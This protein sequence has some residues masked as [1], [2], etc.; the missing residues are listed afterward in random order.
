LFLE[1]KGVA[2]TVRVPQDAPTLLSD[3][4]VVLLAAEH[5]LRP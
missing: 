3:D 1:G 2:P 4:D 5:A